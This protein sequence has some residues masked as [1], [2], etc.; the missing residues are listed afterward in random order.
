MSAAGGLL[1]TTVVAALF[2][3]ERFTRLNI[4]GIAIATCALGILPN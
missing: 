2:L 4:A 3:Q 1:F